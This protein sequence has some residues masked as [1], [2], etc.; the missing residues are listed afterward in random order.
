MVER[1]CLIVCLF[2]PE[3]GVIDIGCVGLRWGGKVGWKRGLIENGF[4]GNEM[5]R[6]DGPL[7]IAVIGKGST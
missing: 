2:N 1:L 7:C 5:K 6:H 3:K 4:D